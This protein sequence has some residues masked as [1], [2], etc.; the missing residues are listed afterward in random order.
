MT[1]CDGSWNDR[2]GSK[3]WVA[4]L[5]GVAVTGL[6]V[7]PA[8]L[9]SSSVPPGGVTQIFSAAPGESIS[10]SSIEWS[11][12]GNWIVYQ[13]EAARDLWSLRITGGDPIRLTGPF[14]DT[15]QTSSLGL[16]PDSRTVIYVAQ[17]PG[18]CPSPCWHIDGLY[19]VPIDGG[20]S[21]LLS[22]DEASGPGPGEFLVTPDSRIMVFKANGLYRVPVRGGPVVRLSD[23]LIGDFRLSPDGKT[24]LFT[25]RG[26]SGLNELFSVP[27]AG[28]TPVRLGEVPVA[29][30]AV[31]PDSRIVV[32][33]SEE[34]YREGCGYEGYVYSVSIDGGVS[35]QLADGLIGPVS[36]LTLHDTT[37]LYADS[38][39]L[40]VTRD[41]QTTLYRLPLE[42]GEPVAIAQGWDIGGFVIPGTDTVLYTRHARYPSRES[43][44]VAVPLFGGEHTVLVDGVFQ[45]GD[46]LG[47]DHSEDWRWL[48]YWQD[49][50]GD[51]TE[52]RFVVSVDALT[53]RE[54]LRS[55]LLFTPDSQRIVG[56]DPE[57]CHLMSE[58]IE[59]GPAT[60]VVTTVCAHWLQFNPASPVGLLGVDTDGEKTRIEEL[61]TF[62]WTP[63]CGGLE[64]TIVG[65]PEA[66]YLTGTSGRDVVMA[67]GGDDV[68]DT[69]G[70]NDVICAGSGHDTIRAGAGRDRIF[71]GPGNDVIYAGSGDDRVF[72]GRGWD[73]IYG[74]DGEDL[75]RGSHGRD[76]IFGGRDADHI[77]GQAGDDTLVGRAGDDLL[78]GGAGDDALDGKSGDDTLWGRAG[79]DILHGNDGTDTLDGG[80]GND[81]CDG[82][83][84]ADQGSDSCETVIAIP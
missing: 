41:E 67:L 15:T 50:D 35:T 74:Q 12:D 9:G 43:E 11:P 60:P 53:R 45:W 82:G 20:P 28:G 49:V 63:R 61:Y 78:D 56:R 7:A 29:N 3:W 40:T 13:R 22:T 69:F 42:G 59:G 14:D 71:A 58:R 36:N 32:Y 25:R 81:L 51:G 4:L 77:L 6:T 39:C 66:D 27:L 68:I 48:L 33:G 79:D 84:D 38:Y 52:E 72:A 30:F 37:V 21:T 8:A 2:R 26:D 10:T 80:V 55:A 65:T 54:V 31:S 83:R 62:E 47:R 24:V 5:V 17:V 18:D 75:I 73:T 46:P 1:G 57:T 70:G 23:G 64:P 19:S 34:F 44:L 16:T 76:L